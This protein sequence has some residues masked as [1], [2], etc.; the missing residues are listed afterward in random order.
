MAVMEKVGKAWVYLGDDSTGVVY[1]DVEIHPSGVLRAS[2]RASQE[3]TNV[4]TVQGETKAVYYAPHA[5]TRVEPV[6]PRDLTVWVSDVEMQRTDPEWR[7]LASCVGR[8]NVNAL[9]MQYLR[10]SYGDR[11]DLVKVVEEAFDGGTKFGSVNGDRTV[12]FACYRLE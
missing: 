5:W 8:D 2:N 7:Q 6:R 12:R 11:D 4:G 3:V 9:A 1:H 10:D